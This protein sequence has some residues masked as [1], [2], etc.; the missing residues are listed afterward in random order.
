MIDDS[1]I[2]LDEAENISL[3]A[4]YVG[5]SIGDNDGRELSAHL[6]IDAGV[7]LTEQSNTLPISKVLR[8]TEYKWRETAKLIANNLFDQPDTDIRD[9]VADALR[10]T[11]P[12]LYGAHDIWQQD[13]H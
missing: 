5:D 4:M 6:P 2:T 3:I 11:H 10:E 13:P 7:E 12:T 1:I 9:I 8:T